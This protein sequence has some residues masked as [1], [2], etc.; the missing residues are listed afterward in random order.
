MN[1]DS[2]ERPTSNLI[3]DAD[4]LFEGFIKFH[5]LRVNLKLATP[6]KINI[7]G[8]ILDRVAILS[9]W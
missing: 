4:G 7:N 9:Y 6:H 2:R 3:N 8:C 1:I 5:V